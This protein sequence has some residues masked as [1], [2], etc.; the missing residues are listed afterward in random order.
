MGNTWVTDM[1]HFLDDDGSLADMPNRPMNLALYFGS[2]VAWMTS[3]AGDAPEPTN[4]TCRRSPGRR[5]CVGEIHASFEQD[6]FGIAWLCPFCGDNGFIHG[7][8][9][10]LWDRGFWKRE[11]QAPGLTPN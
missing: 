9:R 10:T 2:I 5:R 3:H 7:W 8:E 4:V 1:R 11:S 6:P